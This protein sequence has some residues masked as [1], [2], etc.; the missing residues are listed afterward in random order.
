MHRLGTGLSVCCA[1]AIA[2][3]QAQ[4][5]LPAG[6]C[7]CSLTDGLPA[8]DV[9]ASEDAWGNPSFIGGITNGGPDDQSVW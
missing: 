3:V 2:A 7:E 8:A 9:L 6:V 5:Q 1:L 4:A